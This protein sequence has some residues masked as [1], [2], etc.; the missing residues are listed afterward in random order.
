MG[1]ENLAAVVL[2]PDDLVVNF[3]GREYIVVA[4]PVHVRRKN[5][6]RPVGSGRDGLRDEN[7]A[8][9]H[10]W[11]DVDG[12]V[13]DLAVERHTMNPK[14]P[15]GAQAK[16]GERHPVRCGARHIERKHVQSIGHGQAVR[17]LLERSAPTAVAIEI[18]P[19]IQS[20]AARRIGDLDRD[21]R[22]KLPDPYRTERGTVFV[23]GYSH[24]VVC[25]RQQ[26]MDSVDL[27]IP[28]DA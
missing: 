19:G 8:S 12:K 6:C 4:I 25:V 17:D 23:V 7:L 27:R 3:R 5:G 26:R 11:D 16:S 2:V 22:S 15:Q 21:G 10:G 13:L 18:D 20:R 24:G 9:H 14:I 1:S 28:M